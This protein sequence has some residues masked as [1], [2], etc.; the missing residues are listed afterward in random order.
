V[1]SPPRPETKRR[2]PAGAAS[3]FHGASRLRHLVYQTAQCLGFNSP[4]LHQVR[5]S[6]LQPERPNKPMSYRT[7]PKASQCPDQTAA[8][9]AR[10]RFVVVLEGA[11]D[12]GDAHA[13]TLRYLLKY[14]LRSRSLRCTEVRELN[15]RDGVRGRADDGDGNEK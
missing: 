14:L 1:R 3:R 8:A 12:A 10:T 5:P 4:S 6:G 15:H 11:A 13:H 9:D 2:S 7:S